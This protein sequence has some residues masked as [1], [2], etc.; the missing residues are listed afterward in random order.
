M[1]PDPR[2]RPPGDRCGVSDSEL[3]RDDGAP[4][5][6]ARYRRRPA[7]PSA[8]NHPHA[9]NGA[10]RHAVAAATVF[11][12]AVLHRDHAVI[13]EGS[14]ISGLVPARDLP[15]GLPVY[16]L[17]NGAWLA[18]GFID[19]QVNGGGDVLFNDDPSPEGIAAIVAAHRRFGTT[20]LLPTLI[21]DTPEKMRSALG[22]VQAMVGREPGVLGIHFEG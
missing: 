7:A 21:S 22:A 18:P 14:A 10:G 12:G 11:D 4:R 17:P 1:A 3:L 6:A 13:I 5:R 9:M 20:A 16:H 8:K 15:S 2:S 19:V